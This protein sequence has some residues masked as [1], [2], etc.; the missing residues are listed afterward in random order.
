MDRLRWTSSRLPALLLAA[1]LMWALPASASAQSG[2]PVKD[3][4]KVPALA[5]VLSVVVPG[6]GQAYNGQ[7]GKGALILGS[8]VAAVGLF[9]FD[10]A[11]C[12]WDDDGENCIRAAV[13][14][15][16]GA[17]ILLYSWID[18]PM[19][20]RAINRRI[21]LGDATVEMGPKLLGSAGPLRGGPGASLSLI[22]MKF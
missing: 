21:D 17:A 22:R 9:G 13:G 3:G 7:W 5:F 14:L 6:G 19:T 4:R 2:T 8:T 10:A 20:A 15:G 12:A 16:I 18:A 11:S 1:T